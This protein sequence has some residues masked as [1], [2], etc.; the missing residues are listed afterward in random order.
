ME[1]KLAVIYFSPTHTSRTTALAV[2]EGMAELGAEALD[3]DL[4]KPEARADFS[5]EL[6]EGD[7]A[8]IGYPV[9]AGRVPR[10]RQGRWRGR[11]AGGRLRQP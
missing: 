11:R 5:L 9:Y 8:V 7:V 4:T 2:A 1:G 6:A 3:I 10:E